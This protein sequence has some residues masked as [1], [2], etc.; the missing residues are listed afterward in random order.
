MTVVMNGVARRRVVLHTARSCF[1]TPAVLHD[2]SKAGALRKAIESDA[3]IL[4]DQLGFFIITV[5]MSKCTFRLL[6]W[7]QVYEFQQSSH[8]AYFEPPLQCSG[9]TREF[10][11][12]CDV[13]IQLP[14]VC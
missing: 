7:T 1:N 12:D 6:A 10:A 3:S 13:S 8:F 11:S 4:R 9:D 14:E 5:A 2:V